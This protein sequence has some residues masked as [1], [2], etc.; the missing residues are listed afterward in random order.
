MLY[1]YRFYLNHPSGSIL[2]KTTQEVCYWKG[3]VTQADLFSKTCK[4]CQ[5][6]KN[7]KTLYGHL[8]PKN[9]EELKPWDMVHVDLIGTYINSIRQPH[10]G[11]A[12]INKNFSLT[13]MAMIDPITDWFEI[14][15]IPTLDPDEEK[16]G[17]DEYIDK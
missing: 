17:N 14:F 8:P 15:Q 5:Q 11:S 9:I 1:W 16:I 4:I 6:F 10:P 3:L 12:I 13:C 2:S 7:R